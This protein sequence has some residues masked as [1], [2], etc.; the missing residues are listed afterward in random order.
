MVKQEQKWYS[1]IF[2]KVVNGIF[3]LIFL[4]LLITGC[5]LVGALICKHILQPLIYPSSQDS[6]ELTIKT[7]NI[8]L[9]FFTIVSS[10][11][12]LFGYHE[13]KAHQQLRKS[14][15]KDEEKLKEESEE[16]SKENRYLNKLNIVRI[17]FHLGMYDKASYALDEITETINYEVL[18]FKGMIS[19]KMGKY[20][21]ALSSL[22]KALERFSDIE[23]TEKARIYY[24][25]GKTYRYLK[26]YKK[27][28]SDYDKCLKL[29]PDYLDAYIGKAW[30]LK[31]Q[32]KLDEA[33]D[34]INQAINMNDNDSVAYFNRACY[35]NLKGNKKEMEQDLKQ[36]IKLDARLVS[37]MLID[38]DFSGSRD[39]V[40]KMLINLGKERKTKNKKQN[41]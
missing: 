2:P 31:R 7:M 19:N 34:F 6:V 16:R 8:I 27:A 25:R 14:L 17:F 33:M 37:N 23:D 36:A 5:M 32:G 35:H 1:Q 24:A 4:F 22:K 3:L 11:L 9:L 39:I 40:R 38:P 29:A 12:A 26:N 41:T 18:L 21:A 15:E 10:Y 28:I 30:I 13:F 20:Q